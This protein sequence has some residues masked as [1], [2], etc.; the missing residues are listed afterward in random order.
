MNFLKVRVLSNGKVVDMPE[1]AALER[2]QNNPKEYE[3]VQL[4]KIT[5]PQPQKKSAAV[6]G[7]K[8]EVKQVTLEVKK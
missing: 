4:P 8:V 6:V 5:V 2:V 7:D 1:A 3:L